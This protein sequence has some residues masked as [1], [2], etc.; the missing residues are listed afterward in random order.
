MG[1][2]I[3]ARAP[4]NQ[5]VSPQEIP[6][7]VFNCPSCGLRLSADPNL[8]GVRGP[9][10]GC[11]HDIQ[12]P[13]LPPEAAPS[14]SHSIPPAMG[15]SPQSGRVKRRIPVDSIIDHRHLEQR[16]SMKSILVIA[17][18]VLVICGCVAATLFLKHWM[19]R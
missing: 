13:R 17:L 6:P 15:E 12:A 9:C 8:A 5:T 7:L 4:T 2:E 10:P 19:A 16:E 18:F 14:T 1:L 11:G 3:K